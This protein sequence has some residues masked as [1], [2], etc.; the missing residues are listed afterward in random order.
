MLVGPGNQANNMAMSQP[1]SMT[2]TNS[3]YPNPNGKMMV[4]NLDYSSNPYQQ[5][6]IGNNMP[7]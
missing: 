2:S 5:Y 3:M 7:N 6:Y 4:S 1:Y